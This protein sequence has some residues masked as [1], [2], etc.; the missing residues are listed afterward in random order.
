[1][2]KN[3]VGKAWGVCEPCSKPKHRCGFAHGIEDQT[4]PHASQWI[5]S[6]IQ[7]A[8]DGD[9]SELSNLKLTGD[10]WAEANMQELSRR[11]KICRRFRSCLQKKEDGSLTIADICTGGL[12]CM[13]GCCGDNPNF[14][15]SDYLL[16]EGDWRNGIPDGK[17]IKLTELGLIPLVEQE[18]QLIEAE[19]E[20][21]HMAAIDS[22]SLFPFQDRF[23]E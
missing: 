2:C 1:M 12:A 21:K 20:A 17:G 4:P 9:S 13:G 6:L 8:K 16:D 14:D 22:L 5:S 10:R 23:T 18:R 11:S 7:K 19:N 3:F 15:F